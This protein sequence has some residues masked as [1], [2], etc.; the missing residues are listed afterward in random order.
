MRINA[1]EENRFSVYAK[2]KSETAILERWM[3]WF[4]SRGI[5]AEM[6]RSD[7]GMAIYREG[8]LEVPLDVADRSAGR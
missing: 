6:H 7:S 8:L 4:Q 5:P 1:C 3:E 2:N